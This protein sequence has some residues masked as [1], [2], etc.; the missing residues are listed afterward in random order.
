MAGIDKRGRRPLKT[1]GHGW[2]ASL[3]AIDTADVVRG[4]EDDVRAMGRRIR[5]VRLDLGMPLIQVAEKANVSPGWLSKLER[6]LKGDVSMLRVLSVCSVL[7]V[8]IE[9]LM[10]G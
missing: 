10:Y 9:G 3:L 6:G 5:I 7:G 8:S 2:C 4:A 1:A